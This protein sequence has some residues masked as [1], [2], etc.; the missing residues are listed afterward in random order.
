M[1]TE[2]HFANADD[3]AAAKGICCKNY[4]SLPTSRKGGDIT[5]RIKLSFTRSGSVRDK[6]SRSTI[7]SAA[8][9]QSPVF[10]LCTNFSHVISCHT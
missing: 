5:C 6:H 1:Y 4:V 3:D 7:H 2:N 9:K 8:G 10:L